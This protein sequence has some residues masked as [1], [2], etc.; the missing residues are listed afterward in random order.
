MLLCSNHFNF[1][2]TLVNIDYLGIKLS[3]II[4][5][6]DIFVADKVEKRRN[7]LDHYVGDLYRDADNPDLNE[8]KPHLNQ[9]NRN[10]DE[11]HS[12][13]EQMNIRMLDYQNSFTGQLANDDHDN[14]EGKQE[15]YHN[16]Q[17]EHSSVLRAPPSYEAQKTSENVSS[18]LMRQVDHQ[19]TLQEDKNYEDEILDNDSFIQDYD[20][21]DNQGF[22]YEQ[23]EDVAQADVG[24]NENMNVS[25]I[26][27]F[28]NKLIDNLFEDKDFEHGNNVNADIRSSEEKLENKIETNQENW[29][30]VERSVPAEEDHEDNSVDEFHQ[31]RAAGENTVFPSNSSNTEKEALI[32]SFLEHALRSKSNKILGL[33][34]TTQ[35]QPKPK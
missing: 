35:T 5:L 32:V 30:Y 3:D 24:E 8:D 13:I 26:N 19:P 21:Y 28:A 4:D 20:E 12:K 31:R 2:N 29:K 23:N 10:F 33:V 18:T 22:E 34:V 27:D 16:Q 11:Q 1:W 14:V 25:S 15:D 6:S 7:N 9:D 17:N